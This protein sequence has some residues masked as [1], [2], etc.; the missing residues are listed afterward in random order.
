MEAPSISTLLVLGCF[1][2]FFTALSFMIPQELIAGV[3]LEDRRELEVPDYFESSDIE[4][5]VDWWEYRLNV[6][7][8]EETYLYLTDPPYNIMYEV[9]VD[10]GERN[11]NFVYVPPTNDSVF[12]YWGYYQ[13]YFYCCIRYPYQWLPLNLPRWNRHEWFSSSGKDLGDFL[14][15]DE[16]DSSDMNFQTETQG[17]NPYYNLHIEFGYDENVYDSPSD[18]WRCSKLYI[19]IGMEF[20]DLKTGLNSYE[21]LTGV[22]WFDIP[23]VPTPIQFVISIPLWICITWITLAFMIALIKALP[24]T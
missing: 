21:L 12:E 19:L 5:F 1:L 2:G 4:S 18:A 22:L 7:G 9:D 11:F 15:Q 20:D 3:D 14:D 10:L 13:N 16:L 24:F 6:T 17:K 23:N 8:G